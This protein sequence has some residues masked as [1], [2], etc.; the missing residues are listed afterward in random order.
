MCGIAGSLDFD[1]WG[2]TPDAVLEAMDQ[3]LDHRGPDE[4]GLW[5]EGPV[6]L[7][8][9][10]LCI[11]DLV[12][13]RQPLSSRDSRFHLIANGEI[14]NADTLR[15]DLRMRGHEFSTRTDVEVLLYAYAE[16]GP[17]CLER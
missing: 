9:R 17:A 12:S 1:G 15:D 6:G 11:V 13:G 3:A 5:R 4:R 10:R 14:Y 8:A 7:V 2:Y 16:H